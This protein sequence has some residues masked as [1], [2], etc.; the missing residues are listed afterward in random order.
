MYTAQC[1]E[2]SK[3]MQIIE[4][5]TN[6]LMEED[7]QIDKERELLNALKTPNGIL[8]CFKLITINNQ[9]KQKKNKKIGM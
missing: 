3:K 1:E 9:Y 7:K 5:E 8:L 6:I 2:L 4:K